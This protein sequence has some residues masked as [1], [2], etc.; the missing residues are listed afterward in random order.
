MRINHLAAAAIVATGTAMAMAAPAYADP[1]DD[2]NQEQIDQAFSKAV[3]EDGFRIT[4]KDAIELAHSTCD[5]LKRGGTTNE[6]LMHIK[7]ATGWKSGDDIG[8]FGSLSLRAYCPNA[9]PK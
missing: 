6:A 5:L 3:R 2:Y 8:T 1:T 9:L 4:A 7:N